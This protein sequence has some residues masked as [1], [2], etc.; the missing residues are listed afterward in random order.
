LLAVGEQ[1]LGTVSEDLLRAATAL[2]G[3]L[4][5]TKQEACG[6]LSGGALVIGAVHGRLDPATN[7]S[8]CAR[9]TERYYERFVER[10]GASNCGVLR[11]S[12]YGSEDGTPCSQLVAGAAELLLRTLVEAEEGPPGCGSEPSGRKL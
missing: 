3:G 8:H 11:A 4:G 10:F 9:L 7:D 5:L 12:G 2:G 6:A 1:A